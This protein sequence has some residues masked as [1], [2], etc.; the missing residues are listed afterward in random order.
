V[1]LRLSQH[2]DRPSVA[3]I[4]QLQTVPANLIDVQSCI[5]L[6]TTLSVYINIL[7]TSLFLLFTAPIDS[8]HN[9]VK[10]HLNYILFYI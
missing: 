8:S 1:D 2:M 9:L 5:H 10:P 4:P 6:P 7:C 3:Y